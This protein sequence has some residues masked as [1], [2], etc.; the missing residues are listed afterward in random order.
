VV[1][2]GDDPG[3]AVRAVLP[4]GADVAFEALG[5]PETI[6]LATRVTGPGG[7][8]VLVGMAP[9]DAR[10]TIDA[11]TITLE[12]RRVIGCWY[13]SCVPP[14]DFPRLVDLVL[15]GALRLDVMI[16]RTFELDGIND[17]LALFE[18]GPEARSVICTRSDVRG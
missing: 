6:E 17:A 5:R 2:G 16:G 10:P 3:A 15:S 12:E 9:P 13:G 1:L 7:T 18:Q 8:A 11:L 14:R 4:A